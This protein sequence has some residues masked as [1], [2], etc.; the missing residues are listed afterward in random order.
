[1]LHELKAMG[2]RIAIDD[3]GTGYSSLQYLKQLPVDTLKIDRYFVK[4]VDSLNQIKNK[5]KALLDAI[6]TLGR[7]LEMKVLAEGVETREQMRYLIRA[8][9]EEIQ[10]FYHSKPLSVKDF[11]EYLDYQIQPE[12][13]SV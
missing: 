10:G 4:D 1:M 8:G 3:F 6:I 2:L 13:I 7:N 9:C 11:E 12:V 5:S